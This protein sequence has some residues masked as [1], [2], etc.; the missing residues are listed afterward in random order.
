VASRDP[1]PTQEEVVSKVVKQES[2]ADSFRI[3]G[4]AASPPSASYTTRNS[5]EPSTAAMHPRP[6][7]KAP[8]RSLTRTKNT[9]RNRAACLQP[10]GVVATKESKVEAKERHAHS[11]V[12]KR[13]NS[14]PSVAG[15]WRSSP[16][17]SEE[18]SN[19]LRAVSDT[20]WPSFGRRSSGTVSC[21]KA[22]K[23]S[24]PRCDDMRKPDTSPP[25]LL[26]R[27]RCADRSKRGGTVD[28]GWCQEVVL[29]QAG[30]RVP[31]GKCGFLDT[32]WEASSAAT[33]LEATPSSWSDMS[34]DVAPSLSSRERILRQQHR[35]DSSQSDTAGHTKT[36]RSKTQACGLHETFVNR[37]CQL[38][39]VHPNAH[40]N[41]ATSNRQPSFG[42]LPQST[43]RSVGLSFT[44]QTRVPEWGQTFEAEA[45]A[46]GSSAETQGS[47][48]NQ[49]VSKEP[50]RDDPLPQVASTTKLDGVFKSRVKT[51]ETTMDAVAQHLLKARDT[52]EVME[53]EFG[54]IMAKLTACA[55]DLPKDVQNGPSH[56]Q[57]QYFCINTPVDVT[58][59]EDEGTFTSPMLGAAEPLNHSQQWLYE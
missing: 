16:K 45:T 6:P 14:L 21:S 24:W 52:V 41:D 30:G 4:V 43:M 8:G 38:T 23:A 46:L 48:N 20:L 44:H 36:F 19:P 34:S 58:T 32:S 10:A 37:P 49:S 26:A 1:M 50:P 28:S 13:S 12:T 3:A 11:Q 56:G 9:T 47:S 53:N 5:S 18:V 25:P 54:K 22:A 27:A 7:P 59:C 39:R 15:S 55:V 42:T 17:P 40:C 29:Q 57:P 31:C 33:T 35:L 51:R 2:T